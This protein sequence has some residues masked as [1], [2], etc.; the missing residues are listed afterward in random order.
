M[1]RPAPRSA[2]VLGFLGWGGAGSGAVESRRCFPKERLV[3]PRALNITPEL[4]TRHQNPDSRNAITLASFT[5]AS[6]AH[7]PM[8][9][10][11]RGEDPPLALAPARGRA[12]VLPVMGHRARGRPLEGV[13]EL[14]S[15]CAR[16]SR[17]SSS[18]PLQFHLRARRAHTAR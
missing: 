1:A 18:G 13:G 4:S 8:A 11:R 15:T 16:V 14:A 10:D 9:H 7:A 3:A 12:R 6:G 2:G 5:A 17:R